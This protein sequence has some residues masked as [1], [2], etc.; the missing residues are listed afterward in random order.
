[1]S[2]LLG[3]PTTPTILTLYVVFVSVSFS[4]S[5]SLCVLRVCACVCACVC[6]KEAPVTIFLVSHQYYTMWPLHVV[7]VI[8]VVVLWLHHGASSTVYADYIQSGW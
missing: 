5:L 6:V 4:L 7:I 8:V 3:D 1:M 2:V